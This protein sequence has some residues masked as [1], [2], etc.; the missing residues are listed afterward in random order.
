MEGNKITY[1]SMDDYISQFPHE[2]QAILETLRKVIKE[3]A[4]D[5]KEKISYQMPTFVLHGN[6][7]H[8][9]AYK[10]HIGFYPAPSG[11]NAFK[12]ELSKY[13]GAKGSIQFPIDKPLPYELIRK[14]VQFRV[15]E[16]I[17]KAEGKLKKKK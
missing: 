7:V 17:E 14:I 12:H 15:A 11:I 13:K 1:E 10:N 6:L 2:V 16:N 3:S 5:A 8:F 9:A 4:P